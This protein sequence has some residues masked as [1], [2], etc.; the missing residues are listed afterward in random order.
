M[1]SSRWC[2]RTQRFWAVDLGSSLHARWEGGRAVELAPKIYVI[3]TSQP[4]L[5]K[6]TPGPRNL[7]WCSRFHG[8]VKHRK[9]HQLINWFSVGI[10]EDSGISTEDFVARL[11]AQ[12]QVELSIVSRLDYPTSG[13][14]PLA[15]GEDSPADHW[16]RAQFAGRLVRKEYLCLCEGPALG[17]VGTRGWMPWLLYVFFYFELQSKSVWMWK[18]YGLVHS[19]GSFLH[20][21][22][23]T[24]FKPERY[25]ST[26]LSTKVN[27]K[28]IKPL[29]LNTPHVCRQ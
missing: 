12:L 18:V 8:A 10:R 25:C 15:I 22:M 6:C 27:P 21:C 7:N 24:W 29:H 26:G 14:L 5:E 13:V 4:F 1:G 23:T 11:T 3:W 16:V 9:T 17:E 20:D 19:S 2:R 28:G